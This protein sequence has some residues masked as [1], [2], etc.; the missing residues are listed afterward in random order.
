MTPDA[1]IILSAGS[2]AY[3]EGG[4]THWRATTYDNSDAFGT[5]GGRDRLEAAALLAEKYPD[6][7]F[8]T[9]S[10]NFTGLPTLAQIYADELRELGVAPERIIQ[11][12][13]STNTE[14]VVQQAIRLAQKKGW[15]KIL[16]LSSDYHLPRIIAFYR[17]QKDDILGD[18]V[19]SESILGAV[20]SKFAARFAAVQKTAAYQTRI[21]SEARGLAALEEGAYQS[22]PAEDKHEH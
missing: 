17:R 5:L 7:Y 10:R 2:I 4:R 8:V 19:S 22:A 6:A 9:V 15:K 1:I 3:E 20:D 14:T 21:A 16:F 18:F 11:E 12:E 13:H